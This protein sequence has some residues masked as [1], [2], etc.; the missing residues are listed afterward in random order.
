MP[1]SSQSQK[2][3][4]ILQ[5][6]A[7]LRKYALLTFGAQGT[8]DLAVL[9]AI[10][11]N[12]IHEIGRYRVTCDGTTIHGKFSVYELVHFGVLFATGRRSSPRCRS[13]KRR[14]QNQ[15][16][17]TSLCSEGGDDVATAA[18]GGEGEME[19][20]SGLCVTAPRIYPAMLANLFPTIVFKTLRKKSVRPQKFQHDD[21]EDDDLAIVPPHGQGSSSQ[22]SSIQSNNSLVQATPQKARSASI[23]GPQMVMSTSLS[24]QSQLQDPSTQSS[25]LQDIKDQSNRESL[26]EQEKEQQHP[27]HLDFTSRARAD[28]DNENAGADSDDA[29]DVILR[30]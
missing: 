18:E 9:G 10:L 15:Q 16:C 24:L 19:E 26:Q 11:G 1:R 6:E 7:R 30:R 29:T 23:S 8:Q 12:N 22:Q 13:N 3:L 20:R 14:R 27:Y 4:T 2:T 25:H 28:D 17:P 5:H 21:G